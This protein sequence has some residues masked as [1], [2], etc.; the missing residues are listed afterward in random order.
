VTLIEL[1]IV[2]TIVGILA[3]LAGALYRGYSQRAWRVEGQNLLNA[4]QTAQE[5]YRN[6]NNTYTGDLAELGF[7][8]GCSENCVYTIDFTVTPD[9]RTY[10]ARVT[11]TPGGGNNDVDQSGD[12]QCQWLT[13]DAR[14]VRASGPHDSCWTR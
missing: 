4:I 1:L 2:L 13:I 14:G 9:T 11:P 8:S 7:P 6:V 5:N 12:A 10:T 3:A